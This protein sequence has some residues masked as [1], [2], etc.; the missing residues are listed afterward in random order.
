MPCKETPAA[1]NGG[2]EGDPASGR[3][4]GF[5]T[6]VARNVFAVNARDIAAALDARRV[7]PRRWMARCFAHEDRGPSLSITERDGRILFHCFAGCPQDAVLGG[8]RARGLWPER[9]PR[10]WTPEQKR[11]RAR[12]WAAAI[13]EGDAA[14]WWAA[15]LGRLLEICKEG[16]EGDEELGEYSSRL[17]RLERATP[18]AILKGYRRMKAMNTRGA[19]ALVRYGKEDEDHAR[20]ITEAIVTILELAARQGA[21][22]AAA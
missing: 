16:A 9:E 19:A 11:Q 1:V 6:I 10:E 14:R 20:R 18:E 4:S 2:L 17:W 22:S 13:A 8:L 21:R 15:A 5:E 12:A 7:G 3:E